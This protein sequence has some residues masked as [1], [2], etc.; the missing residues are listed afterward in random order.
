MFAV[1]AAFAAPFVDLLGQEIMG[2][3]FYGDSSWGKSTLVNVA[4]SV[5]GNPTDYKKAWRA[6]DNGMESLAAAHSDMLLGLDEINQ[7]DPRK[8]GD[9]IYML[10]NGSGKTRANDRGGARDDLYRWCLVFLSNGEK[11]LEQYTGEAGKTQTA[12][13]EMRF[14]EIRATLQES[15]EDIKRMGVFNNPHNFEGGAALSE[16]LKGMMTKYHGTA[17]PA[18]INALVQKLEN[19]TRD[20]FIKEMLAHMDTFR[21]K[22]ITDKASGQ[23]KRA[24]LKF[25]LVAWA[26][27]YATLW[28][29]TGWRQ[30]Q[31]YTAASQCFKSWLSA[32]GTEGNFEEMQML[33]HVRHTIS[34]YGE[35]HFKRW[36]ISTNEKN[37]VVD[38][39][40]PIT[41]ESWGYRRELTDK[42]ALDGDSSDVE[43]YVSPEAFKKDLCKGFDPNRV[44]RLLR[45]SEIL[46]LTPSDIKEGRLTTKARLPRMGNKP[47]AIYRIRSSKLFSENDPAEEV[48]FK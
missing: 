3:H 7:F 17:F 19:D 22:H 31:A 8:L 14:L 46:I 33:E 28:G 23:V 15:E 5:Y 11:T 21:K 20:K 38:S 30:G 16:H 2:F 9:A 10:G 36:D 24:A 40:A 43:Y 13:M 44:A 41:L 47:T 42:N 27:E 6:T 39:H 26:G 4:C 29:I 34:K 48:F 18:F 32:R 35:S 12:G 45:D 37:A 1:S 25:G